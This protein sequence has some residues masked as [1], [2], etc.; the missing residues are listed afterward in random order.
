ME[1]EGSILE[2]ILIVLT[3]PMVYGFIIILFIL[4]VFIGPSLWRKRKSK[5]RKEERFRAVVEKISYETPGAPPRVYFRRL[6]GGERRTFESRT[7]LILKFPEPGTEGTVFC[8]GYILYS[9][10]W[11]G[12]EVIQDMPTGGTQTYSDLN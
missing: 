12:G 4:A 7:P 9:F 3:T 6:D 11:D 8:K 10:T 1:P 5:K 2:T